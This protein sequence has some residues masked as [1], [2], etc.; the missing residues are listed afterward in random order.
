MNEFIAGFGQGHGRLGFSHTDHVHVFFPEP[1]GKPRK[2]TVACYQAETVHLPRIKNVHSV[3]DHSHIRSVLSAGVGKLLYRR[4]GIFQENLLFPAVRP[5]G[6][7]PIDPAEGRVPVIFNLIKDT[8]RIFRADILCIYQNRKL[9][10]FFNNLHLHPS[11]LFPGFCRAYEPAGSPAFQVS[12]GGTLNVIVLP[13]ETAVMVPS[14]SVRNTCIP[15][16][17]RRFSTSAWG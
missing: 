14:S 15:I 16:F 10:F 17:R 11:F 7:V 12:L 5:A 4:D 9:L 2:I 13:S 3:D 6:P 1:H 8:G